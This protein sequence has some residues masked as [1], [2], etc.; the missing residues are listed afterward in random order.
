MSQSPLKIG[1]VSLGQGPRPDLEALH[2]RLFGVHGLN[3][4]PLWD[5]VLDGVTGAELRTMEAAEGMPAIRALHH[6]G[7]GRRDGGPPDLNTWFDRE[8]L[9]ARLGDAIARLEERGV[10]LTI[11]CAAEMLPALNVRSCRPVIFPAY[12][13]AGQA[14]ML[15]R[16]LPDARIGLIVYGDRQRHQQLEGWQKQ[17]WAQKLSIY[18]SGGGSDVEAI[19]NDLLPVHPDMVFIWAYGAATGPGVAEEIS[20]RLGV[21][22]VSAAMAAVRLSLSFLPARAGQVAP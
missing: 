2:E 11:V 8:A 18:F 14:E 19:V 22:V 16:T 5:H 1:F 12:A 15:A 9:T 10:A 3:I 7:A 4:V 13:M 17:P 6:S 21:P 20:W